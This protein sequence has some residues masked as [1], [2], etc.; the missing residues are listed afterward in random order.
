M[1]ILFM[2]YHQLDRVSL[3]SFL[4]HHNCQYKRSSIAKSLFSKM[5]PR[6]GFLLTI[7]P[8]VILAE[9][10]LQTLGNKKDWNGA[11]IHP[12]RIRIWNRK[13]EGF[14]LFEAVT[15]NGSRVCTVD[16]SDNISGSTIEVAV[17]AVNIYQKN[18]PLEN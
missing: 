4:A 7:I 5:L 15:A 11:L 13:V 12:G 1:P 16:Y 17:D 2:S 18:Y 10:C 14:K 8:G 3:I 9:E 6:L